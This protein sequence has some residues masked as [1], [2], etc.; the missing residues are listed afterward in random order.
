MYNKA[1]GPLAALL[2]DLVVGKFSHDAHEV[3]I[4]GYLETSTGLEQSLRLLKVLVVW[5]EDD[6]LPP[7]G[8]FQHVVDAN[9]EAS[10]HVCDIGVAI[11]AR[12]EA[13]TDY[14]SYGR[15]FPDGR[16]QQLCKA[17]NW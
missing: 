9:P 2:K 12:Q 11:Y 17:Y 4:T 15:T 14:R 5:P 8:R 16:A 13:E 7:N 6:R 10:A 1:S 3:V